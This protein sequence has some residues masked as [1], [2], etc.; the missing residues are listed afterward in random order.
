MLAA[1]RRTALPRGLPAALGL[2]LLPSSA[3]AQAPSL[4]LLGPGSGEVPAAVRR[5]LPSGT[6]SRPFSLRP[7]QTLGGVWLLGAYP[8]FT[9]TD[10]SLPAA[11]VSQALARAQ[12]RIDELDMATAAADLVAVRQTVACVEAPV[13]TGELWRLHFL[14]AVASSYEHGE[15]AARP[16]F[17]RAVAV[18]PSRF[19]DDSYSPTLHQ[20][21]LDAQKEALRGDRAAIL[22]ADVGPSEPGA[23]WVDGQPA[24]GAPLLVP[25]GEHVLQVRAPDGRLRGARLHLESGSVVAALLPA[26]SS[27]ALG[28]LDGERQKSLAAWVARLA[29]RPGS[30]VW[31]HDGRKSLLRLGESATV[32]P[33]SGAAGALGAGA[34][35]SGSRPPSRSPAWG[36]PVFDVHLGGGWMWT[37]GGHYGLG[38]ADVSL[39]LVRALRL[40]V[41]VRAGVSQ[42]VKDP[43]SGEMLGRMLL[44]PVALGPRLRVARPFIQQIS[45][46]FQIAAN[47]GERGGKL[48]ERRPAAG[49]LG[50][51][52]VEIPLGDSPLVLRPHLEAGILGRFFSLRALFGLG[53]VV[54]G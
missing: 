32:A 15:I 43:G 23:L 18:Q 17:A 41:S 14:E 12:Q 52:G 16:A 27:A 53:I 35:S 33:S 31:V 13:E 26:E 37:G 4:V 54:P 45:V 44:V 38:A 25:P 29:G 49:L 3:L 1:R 8:E 42:A 34:G 28:R 51:W 7:E 9:C 48:G 50:S 11:T 24:R 36:D 22:G 30:R 47:E 46:Q 5:E 2:L 6:E 21:Y 10:S 39:R 19:F 20:L 40:A